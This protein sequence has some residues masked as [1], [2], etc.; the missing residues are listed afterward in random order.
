MRAVLGGQDVIK[1]RAV[2]KMNPREFLPG[3]TP[4]DKDRYNI[5]LELA[6][7]TEFTRFTH[8]GC[9]G[10]VFRKQSVSEVPPDLEYTEKNMDGQGGGLEQVAKET[11]SETA[12]VGRVGILVDI[13]RAEGSLPRAVFYHAE[14]ILDITEEVDDEGNARITKVVLLEEI[15]VE[16]DEFSTQKEKS[17]RLLAL[18]ESGYYYQQV[19]DKND[20]P[21]DDRIEPV[22]STG[23]RFDHVP[24]YK[25]GAETNRA[26]V[27]DRPPLLGLAWQNIAHYRANADYLE[28]MRVH[29]QGTL[30]ISSSM[31]FKQF[32]EANPSGVSVGARTGH[33]IGENGKAMLVQLQ[34]A[35]AVLDCLKNLV[36]DMVGTG[37]RFIED[38]SGDRTATE[39]EANENK[40]QSDLATLVGNCSDM[41]ESVLREMTRIVG[42]NED[43]VSYQL[44]RDFFDKKLS[45]Q[46]ITALLMLAESGRFAPSDI[47]RILQK[48]SWMPVNRSVEDVDTEVSIDGI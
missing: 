11:V 10:A 46:E 5:Y 14:N 2:P 45:A 32:E 31:S 23:Q 48:S 39:T 38:R 33:F 18:D 19:Y 7:F 12:G 9:V 30:F 17:Y 3:F 22:D 42:A 47:H 15:E 29:G 13:P 1:G 27:I 41:I 34:P 21:V 40:A 24:F 20:I 26:T 37:A 35:Q 44:N 36:R 25:A 16:V 28:N 43:N 8:G 6:L 4:E